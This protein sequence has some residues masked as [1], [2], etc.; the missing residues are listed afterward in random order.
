MLAAVLLAATLSPFDQVVAAE[1]AFSAASVTQ[2]QHEAFLANLAEDAV[3]FQPLPLP[4]RPNHI[5]QPPSPA[6]LTWGPAWVAV[7]GAG[8]LAVSIGPWQFLAPKHPLVKPETTGWFISMWR[9]QPDGSFKV[10]VDT[11][12]ALDMMFVIPKTVQNGLGAADPKPA[13]PGAEAEA[14][15]GVTAAEQVFAASAVRGFGAALAA[16]ADP[17]LRVYRQNKPAGE[18]L[19]ASQPLLAA[20]RRKGSCKPGKIVAAASGDLGY[21]YGSCTSVDKA[22]P[23]ECAFLHVWRKQP[24]GSWKVLV[25]VTP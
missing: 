12:V 8:D 14:R 17:L 5:G 18:G 11:S 4:A 9:R 3:S 20:D 22:H 2:G 23:G 6:K 15:L 19:A 24:D 25:D 13:K 1:R 16:Q 7:S 10:A 21:A